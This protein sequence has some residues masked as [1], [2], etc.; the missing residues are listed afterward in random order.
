MV[1]IKKSMDG[2]EFLMK[3][4]SGE[5][6]LRRVNLEVGFDLSWHEGYEELQAYLRAANLAEEPLNVSGS[7]FH[8]LRADEIYLPNLVAI[9]TNFNAAHLNGAFLQYAHLLN[10]DLTW[11]G[12]RKTNLEYACFRGA[13]LIGT[14]FWGT[15]LSHAD[16]TRTKEIRCAQGLEFSTMYD[17]LTDDDS[18]EAIVKKVNESTFDL[19]LS[20]E[21][22]P[23]S[24]HN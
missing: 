2:V 5:R 8:Q 12:F 19:H 18:M 11:V 9:G 13:T 1:S 23:D 22:L 10:A 4:L 24:R 7:T 15:Q 17:T 21:M 20:R 6:D 14:N 3:V 16:L